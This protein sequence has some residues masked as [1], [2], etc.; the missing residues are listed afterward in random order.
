[1]WFMTLKAS[2]NN[3]RGFVEPAEYGDPSIN[4]L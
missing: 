2:P 3:S 4:A 1:M